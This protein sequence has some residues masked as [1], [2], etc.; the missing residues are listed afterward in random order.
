[1]PSSGTW[2][3]IVA[4]ARDQCYHCSAD[5][6]SPEAEV[7]G[8]PNTPLKPGT[9]KPWAQ[10]SLLRMENDAIGPALS[11]QPNRLQHSSSHAP[12]RDVHQLCHETTAPEGTEAARLI[13]QLWLHAQCSPSP[14]GDGSTTTLIPQAVPD[15]LIWRPFSSWHDVLKRI[16][17]FEKRELCIKN[18]NPLSE[19]LMKANGCFLCCTD[20]T[21]N[22]QPT[23]WILNHC[24]QAPRFSLTHKTS[25]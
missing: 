6:S 17:Q 7:P 14:A 22:S 19:V 15:Y 4:P 16:F 5:H 1:M 2:P 3:S 23:P 24:V 20:L 21:R 9:P 8:L 25:R 11:S 12:T 10:A 13:Q 18:I